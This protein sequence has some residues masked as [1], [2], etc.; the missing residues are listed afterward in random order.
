MENQQKC[1]QIKHSNSNAIKY[2]LECNAYF[3]NKCISLHSE[4]FENH[5]NYNLDKEISEIFTGICKEPEYKDE[6]K[7]YCKDHNILC[8]AACLSKIKNKEDGKHHDCNVCNLEEIKEEKKKLLKENIKYLEEFSNGIENSINEL[9][10]IFENINE[11]KENLKMQISKIFTEIRNAIND[12]EDEILLK[13]D[14]IFNKTFFNEDIIKKSEKLPKQI[15][16]YLEEGKKI[17]DKEWD[18]DKNNIESK[19]N[20]CIY[21]ENHTKNII[22]INKIIEKCSNKKMNIKFISEKDEEINSLITKIKNFGKIQDISNIPFESE[23]ITENDNIDFIEAKLNPDNKNI[24][25]ELI[26]GCNEN[27]DSPNIFHEKCDGKQN[28][29]LFVETTEGIKFGGYTSVGFN[30]NSQHT[31]DNKAFIFSI[32]K[33]KIYN[34]KKDKSAIYCFSGYGPCFSGTSYFNIYIGGD[35]FLKKQCNTSKCNNNT[36]DNINSDFELNNSKEYFY[37]KK[38]EIFHLILA[39]EDSEA[40]KVYNQ[41]TYN[42]IEGVYNLISEPKKFEINFCS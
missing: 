14:D 9:K 20:D 4:L 37:V 35:H 36:Y 12:R 31:K 17:L 15:K 13:L 22:K 8:C 25:F 32:N 33:K 3:C 6:L 41:Y 38:L 21:I 23:I 10:K 19:I 27:N 39:N 18:T 42:F 16:I 7:Y 34:V 40:G 29:I 30:S 28:V 11:S 2:C 24:E 26:Y 5:H 1:S